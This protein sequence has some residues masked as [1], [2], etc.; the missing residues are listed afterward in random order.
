MEDLMSDKRITRRALLENS[1]FL[2]MA[3]NGIVTTNVSL[4]AD[5][6]PFTSGDSPPQSSVPENACDS[7]IHIYDSRFPYSPAEQQPPSEA[8]PTTYRRLQKRLGTTHCIVVTPSA[9]GIDNRCT[10]AA[11][12]EIGPAARGVAVIDTDITDHELQRLAD[13]GICGVRFN[14]A[15]GGATTVDMIE[16]LANRVQALGWHIQIHMPGDEVA[17]LRDLWKRIPT[18]IVF[19]HFGRIPQPAGVQH[20]AFGVIRELLVAD[21][22]WVKLSG[23]YQDSKEGPPAYSDVSRLARAF[24]EIAPARVVWGSD[25]PH[26]SLTR[27]GKALPD[28]ALLFD[29]LAS[30][31][32]SEAARRA[33]LVDNP[34]RLYGFP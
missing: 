12:A 5:P 30:W 22:A 10:L 18:P 19:D 29:L 15:R 16:P 21:R 33:I 6:V 2:V 27:A 13:S 4:A 1:D 32:P 31:A 34:A 11:I 23:A 8:T 7:H 20:P 28:D 9:Y 24:A 14:I 25:W 26:P 17:R 3:A